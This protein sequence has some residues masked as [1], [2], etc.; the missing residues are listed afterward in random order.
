MRTAIAWATAIVPSLT[1]WAALM[2]LLFIL[3]PA[4]AS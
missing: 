2:V 1:G 3:I 4:V